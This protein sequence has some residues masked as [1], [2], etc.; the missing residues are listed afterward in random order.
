MHHSTVEF[1]RSI[2][3]NNVDG[4]VKSLV[5]GDLPS[6]AFYPQHSRNRI[7]ITQTDELAPRERRLHITADERQISLAIAEGR[8]LTTKF[9]ALAPEFASRFGGHGH[10][11]VNA[12]TVSQFGAEKIATV[13]PF[14]IFNRTWPRLGMPGDQVTVGTEGWVFCQQHKNWSEYVALL[15]MEDAVMGSL[16]SLG[17]QAELSDPGRIAKQMLDHLGGLRHTDL[18]ADRETLQLLNKMAGGI[19]HRTDATG[20]I[21]ETFERRSASAKDWIE[22]ISRRKERRPYPAL[23]LEN[24][25]KR[26]LIRLGLETV[27]PHC[28]VTNWHSLSVVDYGVTCERCLNRYD[29]PQAEL[30]ENNRNWHYRVV[31]P[32]SVPDYGRGSYGALL[33]LR[34]MNSFGMSFDKMTFS[35]ALSLKFDG[36][37]VRRIS[38]LGGEMKVT[39]PTILPTCS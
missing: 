3:K 11:W 38:W 1:G 30:R 25:T 12:V 22:L 27:C 28:Q 37:S 10:R 36:I 35:T 18:L 21:E 19:R 5:K 15:T 24:F 2:G 17:I 26:N 31:G 29:F 9:E 6:D 14:N 13:L 4:L 20:T 39:V 7:W 8:E 33:A 23:K 34:V 32:F 16:K